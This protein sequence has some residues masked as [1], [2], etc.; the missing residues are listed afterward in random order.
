MAM[1]IGK[2]RWLMYEQATTSVSMPLLVVLVI[3]L[4]VIFIS[5]GLFAPF[6]RDRSLQFVHLRAVGFRC[7]LL[8][9][10]DVHALRWI[11][12]D[13]Q[14]TAAG[15]PRTSRTVG[16]SVGYRVSRGKIPRHSP[17]D[18]RTYLKP[19]NRNPL[20]CALGFRWQ[21]SGTKVS[22]VV[23]GLPI[24]H[25]RNAR[26]HKRDPQRSSIPTPITPPGSL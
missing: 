23:T 6:Q 25:C 18:T 1:D 4:T 7:N 9:R 11:D 26:P 13:L 2:T 12:S 8:D 17:L 10:G 22:S 5:F 14:R 16:P 15:R 3:W 21:V 20:S 24:T 19:E